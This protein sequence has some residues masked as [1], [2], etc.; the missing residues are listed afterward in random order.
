[1]K[2][3]FGRWLWILDDATI[4]VKEAVRKELQLPLDYDASSKLGCDKCNHAQ[5]GCPA[6]RAAVQT[7][8]QDEVKK[9]R[10]RTVAGQ[11][12]L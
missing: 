5:F 9:H 11:G 3:G 7:P 8:Q 12:I 4:G 2:H 6:C 1:M 10:V